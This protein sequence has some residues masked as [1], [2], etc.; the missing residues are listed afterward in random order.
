MRQ[1]S[2]EEVGKTASLVD[3]EFTS[4]VKGSDGYLDWE[5]STPVYVFIKGN[6]ILRLDEFDV[7][8]GK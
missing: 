5:G 2:K 1:L 6:V 4:H 3:S 7:K 8:G